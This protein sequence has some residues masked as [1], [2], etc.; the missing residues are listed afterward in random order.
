MTTEALKAPANSSLLSIV[1][2]WVAR[3]FD[4]SATDRRDNDGVWTS[5]VRGL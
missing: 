4:R 3:L 2:D 1:F 5:G